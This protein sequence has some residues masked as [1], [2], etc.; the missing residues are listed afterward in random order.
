[1]DVKRKEMLRKMK[2]RC[3]VTDMR[4]LANRMLFGVPEESSLGVGLETGMECLVKLAVGNYNYLLTAERISWL[5][6]G[7]EL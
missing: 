7:Q 2:E 6:Q 1:M 3:A 5:V 4:R